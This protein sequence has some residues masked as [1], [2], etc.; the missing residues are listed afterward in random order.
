MLKLRVLLVSLLLC[1]ASC[2]SREESPASAVASNEGAAIAA[3]KSINRAQQD[4]IRRTRRYALT[5]QELIDARLL[6]AKPSPGEIGYDIAMRPSPDAGSYSIVATPAA[7]GASA[8]HLFT[9]QTGTIRADQ[10]GEATSASPE[11]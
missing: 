9:D 7:P 5:Y 3:L 10:N 4:F 1:G 6:D 8:R 2:I 11:I